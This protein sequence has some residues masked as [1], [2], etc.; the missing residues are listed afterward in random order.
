MRAREASFLILTASCL[1]SLGLQAEEIRFENL[2]REALASREAK[3]GPRHPEVARG[4]TN[5][6]LFL[7]TH[8]Q[9]AE[10][11][12]LLRRALAIDEKALGQKH[13]RVGVETVRPAHGCA[14]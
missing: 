14:A 6:A 8:G 10:A 9:A 13:A 12:S 3:L 4:L 1:L 7:N 5:L 2:Y 11:E